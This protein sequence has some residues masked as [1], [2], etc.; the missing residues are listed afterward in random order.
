MLIR[1]EDNRLESPVI[2][3]RGRLNRI[4]NRKW[5]VDGEFWASYKCVTLL[6]T[7]WLAFGGCSWFLYMLWPEC[8]S[9][10]L[11]RT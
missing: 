4:A 10:A 9:D 2:L 1:R 5:C 11:F 8:K 3:A 7:R 6:V